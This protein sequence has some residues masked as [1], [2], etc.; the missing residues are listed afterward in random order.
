MAPPP[1]PLIGCWQRRALG[2][3]RGVAAP[4]LQTLLGLLLVLR[5][6]WLV[7]AGGVLQAC[8]VGVL[9]GACV[10]EG[11]VVGGGG[12]GVMRALPGVGGGSKEGLGL[13]GN[14]GPKGEGRDQMGV[15]RGPRGGR[16]GGSRGGQGF[17]GESGVQGGGIGFQ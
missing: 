15:V 5:L 16:T 7:G 8:I 6:P 14:Q 9:M 4:S 2:T 13:R 10:S 17:K 1:P 3:L 12:V 11:G